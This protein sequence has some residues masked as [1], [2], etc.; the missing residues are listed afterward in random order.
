MQAAP[1]PCMLWSFPRR[2]RP[3]PATTPTALV[4]AQRVLAHTSVPS[5]LPS[6]TWPHPCYLERPLHDH[7]SWSASSR[8][9][10]VVSPCEQSLYPR[11]TT[12]T[13]SPGTSRF[14]GCQPN[15]QLQPVASL[16]PGWYLHE[17]AGGSPWSLDIKSQ[18]KLEIM[19]GLP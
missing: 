14:L 16:F 12:A 19:G 13:S 6:S 7:L 10:Q 15:V 17:V 4:C 3:L 8:H 18:A 5:L 11:A 2:C 1:V 9:V